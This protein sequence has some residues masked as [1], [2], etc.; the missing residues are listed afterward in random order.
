MELCQAARRARE[1]AD[2]F[3]D[4]RRWMKTPPVL[5]PEFSALRERQ[6]ELRS[7][8]LQ[9]MRGYDVVLCPAAGKPAEPIQGD[10]YTRRAPGL[11][12]TL[13]CSVAVLS[14]TIIL[15]AI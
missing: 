11:S 4:V 7:K 12:Y 1:I 14:P 15:S 9:W 8:L 3:A 2:D 5:T 10:S 13:F 6:D